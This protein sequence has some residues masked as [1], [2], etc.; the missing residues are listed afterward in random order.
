MISR[1]YKIVLYKL[2]KS[3]KIVLHVKQ[4]FNSILEHFRENFSAIF[5]FIA[6][7]IHTQLRF[8]QQINYEIDP[9]KKIFGLALLYL[10]VDILIYYNHHLVSDFLEEII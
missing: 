8:E 4:I 9:P 7:Y 3:I 5:S 10:Q 1:V 6:I 2:C